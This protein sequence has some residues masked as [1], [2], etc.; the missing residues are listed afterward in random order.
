VTQIPQKIE[1]VPLPL[2]LEAAVGDLARYVRAAGGRAVLVGGSV[3]D[4]LLGQAAKDADLEVFGIEPGALEKLVAKAYPVVVVGRSFGVLK[5]R[6][7]DLDVSVPR[8]ER[9][10]GPKHTDFAVDADPGMSFKDAAARRDF[11]CNAISWDPLTRELIDPFNGLDDIHNCRLRH[12]TERFAEDPLRVLRAMQLAARFELAVAPE[13]VALSATLTMEGLSSERVFE[14]WQKLLVKGRKPSAGLEFLRACGWVKFFP[15]LAALIGCAQDPGWHPEGDVWV[16][17]LHCLDAFATR[18]T[19][20]AWE[21]LIVGLAVLCHDLGKP[22]TT[23][24]D[25]AGRIRSP[26]HEAAAEEPARAF[27][28]RMT[29]QK[30]LIE[31]VVPLALCHMRPRELMLGGAGD[32]AIRRLAKKIGR[33]D[34][35]ARV[36]E[37]DR[38]GRPPLVPDEPGA[39]Q[40]LLER[41]AKLAVADQV[42]APIILGRHLI[43]AGLAPGPQF[44]D[45]LNACYEA[46]MDG[47]F[48]DLA[49]GEAFLRGLIKK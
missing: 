32:G 21:D 45:I 4:A 46:Q 36:D 37:A 47:K 29:Q 35:L 9:Q 1:T 11:T 44:K 7:L 16:H 31:S 39:G 8:R 10:T 48:A 33:I 20:D 13:T 41:A 14:E 24:K 49:G 27:L 30:D 40:W 5:V 25:E 23:A 6:G 38:W 28:A 43:A 34:R 26:G 42:P 2:E 19:G 22:A 3:R 18:R 17:T 12:T 15:E